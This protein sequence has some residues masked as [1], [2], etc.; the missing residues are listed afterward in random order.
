MIPQHTIQLIKER[1]ND[2][3]VSIV[4]EYVK[5]KRSGNS[6]KGH[7]PFH[8]ENT[9]SFS[10]SEQKR[11][12]KCFGCDQGGDA[13]DFLMEMEGYDFIEA[14]RKLADHFGVIIDEKLPARSQDYTPPNSIIP[15]IRE[16][17]RHIRKNEAAI[18]CFSDELCKSLHKSGKNN[19]VA[20]KHFSRDQAKLLAKYT[21]Q[22]IVICQGIK[23]KPLFQALKTAL[24]HNLWVSLAVSATNEPEHWIQFICRNFDRSQKI[25]KACIQII[26][27]C[28]DGVQRGIET[29]EFYNHWDNKHN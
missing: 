7:C 4:E 9:P 10:V 19:A 21:D 8:D 13:V 29:T 25:K 26:A 17:K 11:I 20:V 16:A 15:G 28:P 2:D 14:I 5:L 1:A 12:Y 27:T 6:Y 23:Q 18:V 3:I 24:Q 22:L